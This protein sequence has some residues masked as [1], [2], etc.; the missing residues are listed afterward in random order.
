M[1]EVSNA[2]NRIERL[3]RE[4]AQTKSALKES[5][6]KLEIL[7]DNMP[8]G[9]MSYDADTGK[10][11][12]ISKG[13]LS[14]FSCTEETFREHF[15][16][17]FEVF[18]SKLDRERVR[19]QIALQLGYFDT[20]ELTYRVRDL[21]DN[22]M[23]I[24]HK[25]R[26]VLSEDGSSKFY[27]VI[28]D[29]TEEKLVQAHLH[30]TAQRLKDQAELDGMTGLFNKVSMQAAIDECLENSSHTAC[31][32]MLMIDT[33]NFKAVNDTFGHQYGD[34]VI[35]FVADAIRK[36]FRESDYIGRMG[37]D[38][39]MV[40]M[41][42][43]SEEI[44]EKRAELLNDAIRSELTENGVTVNISCSIGISFYSRDGDN[45][46]MLFEAADKALYAAKEAGKD[47]YRISGR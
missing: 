21:F 44:A 36:I 1:S 2:E 8:G 19:E 26:L 3:E 35:V 15:F 42:H 12:F 41:R 14:I 25:G 20:V 7:L 23:W 18:V 4:L 11:D 5:E 43:T 29:I 40:L 34:K 10:F 32:A 39:F 17:S 38:E 16:N 33:D 22:E 27:V 24:Y 9:V 37:G 46:E 28:S 30:Q 6:E 31:H 45:Y 47:C 13:C